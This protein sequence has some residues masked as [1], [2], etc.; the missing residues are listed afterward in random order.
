MQAKVEDLLMG[1][2][3]SS[4]LLRVLFD[5]ERTT[6]EPISVEGGGEKRRDLNE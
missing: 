1:Q 4:L 3:H 6:K 5:A 2:I